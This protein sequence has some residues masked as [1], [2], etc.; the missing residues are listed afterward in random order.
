MIRP[1]REKL[2][3]QN[4]QR[5]GIPR[6]YFNASLDEYDI[7]PTI[8]TIFE[9]YINNLDTMFQDGVGIVCYGKNGSGK[10]Y[11][12]SIVV[13]EAYRSR[14]SSF[15]VTLQELIDLNFENDEKLKEVT[16]CDFLVIDEIGKEVESRNKFN[17]I[18]FEKVLRKRETLGKPTILCMNLNIEDFYGRYGGSIESLVKS[19]N[20]KVL[21]TGEDFRYASSVHKNSVQLLLEDL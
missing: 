16:N 5:R 20:V 10:T 15:L 8:K 14:Y 9:R 2:S 7:D 19:Y 12:S 3:E 21:F 18:V 6:L 17:I 4:L 11:L 13:K 1:K